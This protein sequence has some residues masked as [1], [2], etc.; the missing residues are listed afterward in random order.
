MTYPTITSVNETF[1]IKSTLFDNYI[2]QHRFLLVNDIYK[3]ARLAKQYYFYNAIFG[4]F[5]S[6][7]AEKIEN[8]NTGVINKLPAKLVEF[9]KNTIQLFRSIEIDPVFTGSIVTDTDKS[10][11]FNLVSKKLLKDN[12]IYKYFIPFTNIRFLIKDGTKYIDKIMKDILKIVYSCRH[13]VHVDIVWP[14]TSMD[15]IDGVDEV[16]KK[17][18]ELVNLKIPIKQN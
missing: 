8:N 14:L 7:I 2:T 17:A 11:S 9:I 15:T 10:L 4:S 6:S 1:E 18:Y 16:N 13:N 3:V 5:N 12:N